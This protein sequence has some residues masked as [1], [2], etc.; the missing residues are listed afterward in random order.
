[1]EKELYGLGIKFFKKGKVAE[2]SKATVCYTGIHR[3]KS[4]PSRNKLKEI[5]NYYVI[6]HYSIYVIF[7]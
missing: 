1:M 5:K 7:S 3:F 2:R 6:T 4:Y